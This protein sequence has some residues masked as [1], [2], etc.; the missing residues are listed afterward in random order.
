MSWWDVGKQV[1][2]L[3]DEFNEIKHRVGTIETGTR[4]NTQEFKEIIKDFDRRLRQIER[5][6][7]ERG[8]RLKW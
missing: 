2:E 5:D 3:Y 4:R 1:K 7:Y 8:V 6:V